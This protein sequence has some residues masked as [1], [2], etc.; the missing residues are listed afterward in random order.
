[1]PTVP[2]RPGVVTAAA[3]MMFI[4]GALSACGGL[5]VLALAGS[6]NASD[7]AA[8]AATGLAAVLSVVILI[9]GVAYIVLGVYILKGS[10]VAR[11]LTIVLMAL[12][13]ALT[14]INFEPSNLITI[15]I[16]LTVIGLLAWNESAKEYFAS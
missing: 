4:M 2:T 5:A 16:A 8:E 12:S 1:M 13:I 9:L 7:E 14:F 11:I 15:A 10:N 3:V 6:V